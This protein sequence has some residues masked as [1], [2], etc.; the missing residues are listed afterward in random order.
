MH[1]F[2]AIAWRN[3]MRNKKRSFI[4]IFAIVLGVTAM[5]LL[6]SLF[7]G[8]YPAM[9]D[10]MTSLYMGHIEISDSLYIEKPNL[11]NTIVQ[12]KP[13]LEIIESNEEVLAYS[14]RLRAFGMVQY[15][16]KVQGVAFVG[17]DPAR[18]AAF[19]KLDD[20]ISAGRWLEDDD[21]D[22]VVIGTV[23]AKNLDIGLND[24]I[25]PHTINRW[26][27]FANLMNMTVVGIVK[28]NVPDIDGSLLFM[29]RHELATALFDPAGIEV[30]D[31]SILPKYG[32]SGVF[33]EIAVRLK[34]QQHL[35]KVK[36]EISQLLAERY[37]P[38]QE[39][40]RVELKAGLAGASGFEKEALE[41]DL[42]SP[43]PRTPIVR[44][45]NEMVPWMQQAME[46]DYAFGYLILLIMLIV[47]VAGILNTVLMSV[48]ERTREF[49]IMRALGTKGGQIATVV[50]LEAV[51]L[52][53]LG[54]FIGAVIG[55]AVT[56]VL[57][58]T[59]IDFTGMIDESF[60][61]QFYMEPKF[62]PSLNISH[63]AINCAI[64]MSMVI[65]VSIY[66]ARKAA[67]MVPV[68]AIKALG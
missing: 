10:N 45:W 4:T 20:F 5:I 59:G 67:K 25:T 19:G 60:I 48:M 40:R 57:S 36:E 49:G 3:V 29:N 56:L 8:I 38:L 1:I 22:C 6:W 47:V 14:P 46:M 42:D 63:L 23:V 54:M 24:V 61:G 31:P 15:G 51:M 43:E 16:D 28:T 30:S 34:D 17:V 64:I 55:V 21:E 2:L 62:Y 13:A 11:E 58:A 52:G 32:P 12:G 7:D 65:I 35:Q 53:L 27:D 66:P 41:G 9:I 44:T 26:E 37:A 50:S 39:E 68:E 18:E 33:T